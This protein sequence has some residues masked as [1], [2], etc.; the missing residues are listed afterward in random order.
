MLSIYKASAG[1]GKTYKLAF[2]Y[3]KL[4]LGYKAEGSDRYY[5]SKSNANRHRSILAITF[6][7]KATEE[8]KRRII[9]ELAVLAQME[10]GWKKESSYL[11]DLIKLFGCTVDEIRAAAANALR[12]ILCDF[13]FF[14]ISTIDSF[15]QLILRTFAREAELTGNYELD[16][17]SDY[18]VAYGVN[19]LFQSLAITHDDPDTQRTVKRITDYLMSKME[20]GDSTSLFNRT[21]KLHKNFIRLINDLNNETLATRHAEISEYLADH[22]RIENFLTQINEYR[23]ILIADI[24][25]ACRDAL[26]AIDTHC[27]TLKSGVNG[28][29]TK[30]LVSR[31]T[32]TKLAKPTAMI[33][34]AADDPSST[35]TNGLKKLIETHPM[36]ELERAI[37]SACRTI[38][39]NYGIMITASLIQ[40]NIFVLGVLSKIFGFIEQFRTENNTLLLS[41]TNSLL[42]NIIGEDDT[43][44][45]YERLGLRL[46]H[47]LI[48]EFQDTSRMQWDNLRPMVSESISTNS[49]CLI[50]GDEKQCIYR[51]RNS[52]P[53]LLQHHIEEQ[54]AGQTM[55]TGK[56]E[57][58]N[59]NWR[60][61]ADVVEFNN[62]LFRLLAS[63]CGCAD[64]YANVCQNTAQADHPGYVKISAIE[65]DSVDEY[66]ETALEQMAAEIKRQ[67]ESGYKASEIAV[68][69]RKI[70]EGERV[71]EYLIH[72]ISTDD[73]FPKFRI[74]SDD[75]MRVDSAPSVR[76]IVSALKMMVS[77]D[78]TASDEAASSEP[79]AR[80]TRRDL[81]KFINVFEIMSNK[82]M[83]PDEAIGEALRSHNKYALD[84]KAETSV[85]SFNLTSLVECIISSDFISD[86][87]KENENMFISAFQDIVSDF[88]YTG[89]NDINSFINWWD[90]KGHKSKI[91]APQ[92]DDSLR[93]MT[94][95]KSKGLEFKCVHIPFTQHKMVN[96]Q[97]HE[98][99]DGQ[100]LTDT[101]KFIDPGLIPPLIPIVPAGALAYTPWC[102][103]YERRRKEQLLDELNIL[104]VAFT[105]AIDELTVSYS[106]PKSATCDTAGSY[107]SLAI[108]SPT[109][110][111][112]TSLDGTF[113]KGTP[114]T[115][116]RNSRSKSNTVLE[117]SE[118]VFM[119][120]Y[121]SNVRKDLWDNIN[122]DDIRPIDF[123]YSRHRG[124]VLHNV[125]R[126]TR[127]ASDLPNAVAEEVRAGYI[128][129]HEAQS[130]IDSLEAELSREE[131]KPWF[132]GFTRVLCER[133][134]TSADGKHH[135][136]DRIVWTA[137]GTIDVIDYKFGQE[138]KNKYAR[139][140]NDYIN[141]MR[142]MG[143]ENAKGYVWYLD[144]GKI[145]KV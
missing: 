68:L 4:L 66:A 125:L 40:Q 113:I 14:N 126:R 110:Q 39:D 58:E 29:F 93:V 21:A 140:V 107:I 134:L 2:E 78:P 18:A 131:V 98:W 17:H 143:Y 76:L 145:V 129:H 111:S 117:P 115:P 87:M 82:G 22:S 36:P 106:K 35:F 122:L 79:A 32:D 11:D 53:S 70:A 49:D 130:V 109:L 91:S 52:D 90:E 124:I 67:I 26:S 62:E 64:I 27:S 89:I 71:I 41:D 80:K 19:E 20:R 12:N 74:V 139:Q 118:S 94:I 97:S 138:N 108:N 95:H 47:F 3:I 121:K 144:S 15:F 56:A 24:Q 69:T 57:N 13:S 83:Q 59:T 102:E 135:R 37:Q 38:I 42:R 44:F 142:S 88:S 123:S 6:T 65:A 8:M 51:F 30:L 84:F 72:R 132:D 141:H 100:L 9:H 34:D 85:N 50:I 133:E 16:L 103:Q 86:D 1:S 120:V 61:S 28:K 63:E 77:V 128:P 5:L 127:T 99:F 116:K 112:H 31:S 105:R 60:S 136:P 92:D 25:Q 55:I 119:P 7:N 33:I 45:I 54:F 10:P 73:E 101:F 48:D 43:P 137:G 46:H 81:M 96:F 75:A 104:Y 23:R 114:T